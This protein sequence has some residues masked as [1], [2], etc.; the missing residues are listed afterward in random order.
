MMKRMTVLVVVGILA[1]AACTQSVRP[2]SGQ[3]E[4]PPTISGP[5]GR[6][7]RAQIYAAVIR[8]L[9]TKD[10]T[11]GSGRSPFEYVYV[12]DGPIPEAGNVRTGL[13]PAPQHF[14]DALK[15]EVKDRLQDLPP[16]DFIA[17]PDSVRLGKQGAGGVKNGGVILSLG[18]IEPAEDK[19]HVSTGLWC[20][21][22]CGQWLTYVLSQDQERWKITGTTGPYAIS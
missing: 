19:V 20:G 5:S 17:D 18:P 11:F 8:R 12:V 14:G 16:L 3:G 13:G 2:P 6:E 21:G 7:I 10:H 22:L 1:F 4:P 15:Q 9:V